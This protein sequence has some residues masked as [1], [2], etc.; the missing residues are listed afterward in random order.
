LIEGIYCGPR[1]SEIDHSLCQIN[2]SLT[3][4][5]EEQWEDVVTAIFDYCHLMYD[6][7]KKAKEEREGGSGL[8]GAGEMEEKKNENDGSGEA[9]QQLLRTWDEV[10][11]IRSLSFHQTSPGQAYSLA[12]YL[13]GSVRMNG[14]QRSMSK[15]SLL[16]ENKNT[17]PLD[18]VLDFLKEL[19]PHNCFIEHCSQ[20]AWEKQKAKN[21]EESDGDE[22]SSVFGFKKEKW[23]GVDYH[24]SSIDKSIVAKWDWK[25]EL[26]KKNKSIHYPL[27]NKYIPTD[28]SLCSDLPEEALKGPRID[29]E[30]EPPNLV[31]HD[32]DFGKIVTINYIYFLFYLPFCSHS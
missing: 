10:Q 27:E 31:I 8:G 24:L 3:E 23:Y 28:L 9:I 18:N 29:K 13:A 26:R 4:K 7:V 30:I 6:T 11:K 20:S 14:T 25:Q 22:S 2:V 16:A 17:L 21:A 15:G 1:L 19:T 5:G 32:K 12:P